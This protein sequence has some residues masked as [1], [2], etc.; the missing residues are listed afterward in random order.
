M[1]PTEPFDPKYASRFA[2]MENILA[3]W[4]DF[5]YLRLG[6]FI[7]NATQDEGTDLFYLTDEVVEQ[8]C[9]RF[10]VQ[11]SGKASEEQREKYL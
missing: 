10:W 6:Q 1:K 11:H 7:S 3:M 8:R 2:T 5:P 9:F 4:L